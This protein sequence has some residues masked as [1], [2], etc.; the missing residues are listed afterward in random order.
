MSMQIGGG[1]YS[2]KPG[3]ERASFFRSPNGLAIGGLKAVIRTAGYL[4]CVR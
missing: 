3:K 4:N 2:K 1:H